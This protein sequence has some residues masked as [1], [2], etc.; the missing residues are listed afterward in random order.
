MFEVFV[1]ENP[2]ERS[3]EQRLLSDGAQEADL[4]ERGVEDD[5][6]RT[7]ESPEAGLALRKRA[8]IEEEG[9]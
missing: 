5:A 3:W 4:A 6:G 7:P 2:W 9:C 8:R 1:Q